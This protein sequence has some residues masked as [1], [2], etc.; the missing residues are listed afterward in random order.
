MAIR[1]KRNKLKLI[2]LLAMYFI[3][4]NKNYWRTLFIIYIYTIKY[5]YALFIAFGSYWPFL[6]ANK[7]CCDE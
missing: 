6:D 3:V 5:I 4:I 7:K 1:A 2:F